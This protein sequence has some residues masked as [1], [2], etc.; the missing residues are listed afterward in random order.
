MCV[1]LLGHLIYIYYEQTNR[2]VRS[3]CVCVCATDLI[4]GWLAQYARV[5]RHGI[6]CAYARHNRHTLYL[7]PSILYILVC[8]S[9][10]RF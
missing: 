9:R 6:L 7:H 1:R 2:Y 4:S 10:C 8:N 5:W 3:E